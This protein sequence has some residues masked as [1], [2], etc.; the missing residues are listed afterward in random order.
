MNW[1]VILIAIVCAALLAILNLFNR[2]DDE[3]TVAPATTA[4]PSFYMK[5]ATIVDTGMDGKPRFT[6]RADAISEDAAHQHVQLEQVTVNYMNATQLS[7]PWLL[8]ANNGDLE[9]DT[10]VITFNGDVVLQPQDSHT[11]MPIVLRTDELSVDTVNNVAH[12]PGK[13]SITMNKQL[14]TAVGL[15]ANLQHQIIR[16]ESQVHGEFVAH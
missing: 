2:H 15:Q 9:E 8:T 7:S 4:P 16:L 1:P 14:L 10:R 12:A 6:L 13:V 3:V 11:T 5:Q